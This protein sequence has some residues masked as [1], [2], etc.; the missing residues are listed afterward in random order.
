M[1]SGAYADSIVN[2]MLSWLKGFAGWVL[3]L[4]DLAGGASP[5]EW[6][7]ENWLHLLIMLLIVG[8]AVDFIIWMLRWRPYWVWFRKKR[9][10]INDSNFFAHEKIGGLNALDD[11]ELFSSGWN[12]APRKKKAPAARTPSTR[13]PAAQPKKRPSDSRPASASSRR[14]ASAKNARSGRKTSGSAHRTSANSLDALFDMPGHDK[15]THVK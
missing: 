9:V 1:V 4:F 6:L 12:D 8:I 2:V 5:L 10:I 7:S 14:S 13:I 3:R 15:E 11:D